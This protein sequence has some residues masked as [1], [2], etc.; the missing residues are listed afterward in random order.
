MF[1]NI[2]KIDG[3]VVGHS[4]EY[5]IFNNH[6]I[7]VESSAIAITEN[8][9]NFGDTTITTYTYIPNQ[10]PLADYKIGAINY[11]QDQPLAIDE[12]EVHTGVFLDD[13][14]ENI[15]LIRLKNDTGTDA[16]IID[17]YYNVAT[18]SKSDLTTALSNLTTSVSAK[19]VD[20]NTTIATVLS[21]TSIADI[22]GELFVTESTINLIVDVDVDHF[23]DVNQVTNEGLNQVVLPHDG[24][25]DISSI[26]WLSDVVGIKSING[27]ANTV[28]V[29][30]SN[31]ITT[32]TLEYSAL[33]TLL[34][35]TIVADGLPV[36]LS[37][38]LYT[39]K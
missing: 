5:K 11:V 33:S 21:S 23:D 31:T 30:D 14:Q 27:Q 12:I 37:M 2:N 25:I 17:K 6:C 35:G 39:K 24:V 29:I 36:T 26:S 4:E 18:L 7:C 19:I 10:V 20:K 13:T 15:D 9:V 3:S 28:D 16:T 22:A 8:I 34:T 38:V 1:F 32:S